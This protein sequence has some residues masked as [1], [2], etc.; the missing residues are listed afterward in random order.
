MNKGYAT[1]G[2][3]PANEQSNFNFVVGRGKTG[4]TDLIVNQNFFIPAML[5]IACPRGFYT[6]PILYIAHSCQN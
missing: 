4:L 2:I 3:V 6:K 1:G 5:C